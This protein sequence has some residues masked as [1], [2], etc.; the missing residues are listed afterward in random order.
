MIKIW[1]AGTRRGQLGFHRRWREVFGLLNRNGP[2]D[3]WELAF[4]ESSKDGVEDSGRTVC[5]NTS[6]GPEILKLDRC[7]EQFQS[8][9]I[10]H[11]WHLIQALVSQTWDTAIPKW[12]K[13]CESSWENFGMPRQFSDFEAAVWFWKPQRTELCCPVAG[14]K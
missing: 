10:P 12:Q 14:A 2:L 5:E 4:Y 9:D 3:F 11:R 13:P 1:G 7:C 8:F 6:Y